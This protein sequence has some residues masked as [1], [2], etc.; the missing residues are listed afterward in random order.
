[1]RVVLPWSTCAITATFLSRLGSRKLLG[2]A[3]AAAV[4]VA[5]P[6]E[7]ARGR[8]LAYEERKSFDEYCPLEETECL[9]EGQ[10][11]R[12]N[13]PAIFFQEKIAQGCCKSGP[14]EE[15]I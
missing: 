4:A 3:A 9:A 11:E 1:M 5:E 10:R 7:K 8:P 14:L 2:E 6:E 15:K 12:N 13:G